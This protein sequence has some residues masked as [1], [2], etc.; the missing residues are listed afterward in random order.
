MWY[1]ILVAASRNYM[2]ALGR[3]LLRWTYLYA[4]VIW[5]G[6]GFGQQQ[7]VINEI[8]ASNST[9]NTDEQGQYDDWIELYN[10]G[11]GP[12]DLAGFYLTDDPDNLTKWQFPL[13]RPDLTTIP[14]GGHLCVWADNAQGVAE[15]HACFRL[16]SSGEVV[17]LVGPDCKS[18]LDQ[19]T[20]PPLMPDVSF[21]RIP[22]GGPGWVII[23]TPSPGGPNDDI[24]DGIVEPLQFSHERGFY[25]EP[26]YLELTCPSPDAVIL[27]TLDGRHPLDQTGRTLLGQVYKA[28]I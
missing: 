12:V 26:F 18:I 2:V 7:V 21:G 8:L 15:L 11:Q 19:V 16:D 28:P 27:Y 5:T 14:G 24:F 10:P 1:S 13:D 17:I 20:Y 22:D 25:T 23:S 4:V 9:V 6:C 3:V